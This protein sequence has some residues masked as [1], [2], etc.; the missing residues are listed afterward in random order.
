MLRLRGCR[1]RAATAAGTGC[2]RASVVGRLGAER[3]RPSRGAEP[4]FALTPA[5]RST[6]R[7]RANPSGTTGGSFP[8][9]RRT[10][11]GKEGLHRFMS[12]EYAFP[13]AAEHVRFVLIFHEA[14][15]APWNFLRHEGSSFMVHSDHPFGA[16]RRTVGLLTTGP[17]RSALATE[18]IVGARSIRERPEEALGRRVPGHREGRPVVGEEGESAVITPA[19]RRSRFTA[20]PA[21]PPGGGQQAMRPMCSSI[22]CRG[23]RSR[24]ARGAQHPPSGAPGV[25]HTPGGAPQAST[26]RRERRRGGRRSSEATPPIHAPSRQNVYRPVRRSPSRTRDTVPHNGK[27]YGCKIVVI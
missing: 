6:R 10:A 11:S 20:P 25:L 16:L 22:A 9:S 7:V 23:R 12:R 21:L 27:G 5:V 18:E 14:H 2:G 13:Q 4:A 3:L 19:G 24:C 26:R 1:P 17:G 8:P 15:C